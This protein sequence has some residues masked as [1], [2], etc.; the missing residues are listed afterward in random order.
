MLKKLIRNEW[1]QVPV[2]CAL[3]A[4]GGYLLSMGTVSGIVSPL[5]ASLAGICSPLYIFC[6]LLGSLLSYCVQDAPEGM[7]FLL[8][9][10]IAI[11]C[12]RIFFYDNFKPW[13]SGILTAVTCIGAGIML[14]VLFQGGEGKLPLYILESFMTGT[15]SFFLSDAVQNLREHRRIAL[16]GGKSFTFSICYLLIITALCGIDLEF[17]NLG[18]IIGMTVTLTASRQFRQSA[19]TLCGA[20][21]ACGV[22]LCSVPLGMPLLFLPVTAMLAGFLYQIPNAFYIPVFFLMQLFSSAVLDSSIGIIRILSELIISCTLYAVFCRTEFR[23]WI[24]FPESAPS[25]QKQVIQQEI[26]LSKALQELRE[27]TSAV[28]RHLTVITPP[29]PAEQVRETLCQNCPHYVQ[30]WKQNQHQTAQA[31]QQ[32]LHTPAV[33]PEALEHCPERKQLSAMMQVGSQ[34]RTVRQM[35]NVSLMQNREM[36]LEY[37]HLLEHVTA[38][39]AR[40]RA[41][42]FCDAETAMLKNILTRCAVTDDTGCFVCKLRSGRY[43]AEIYS[44]QESFPLATIQELL[45]RQLDTELKAIS[46]AH[47]H[48]TRYCLYEVP[49]YCM[50][51]ALRSQNA[52]AYERC[53]DHA[54]AFTDAFGNQ[55]LVISDGMGS[56]S[57]ASL[58]SRIAVR[59]F[60]NMVCCDMP[61]DSAI[62]LM[63]ALL[64]TET[65]TENFATLDIVF[66]NADTGEL[67]FCKSG[68]AS[69]LF[70]RD[71]E[72]HQ[73]L[74]QSFP[75]GIVPDAPPSRTK[76]SAQDGD[77]VILLSDGISEAEYP[78]IRQLL[79]QNSSPEQLLNA[80]FEKA[81]VFHGGTVRDDMTVITA[82]VKNQHPV[83]QRKSAPRKRQHSSPEAVIR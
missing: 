35:Q 76:L 30:C 1:F 52:P 27:E 21:T 17:C 64:M 54:D 25:G 62:R 6:I 70:C 51:Y 75:L 8:T 49:A 77:A 57:P 43:T 23:K 11:L 50:E 63:N 10:L 38:D 47:K 29:E 2:C 55:Y 28:M 4:S 24:S 41:L 71:G 60:R 5:A 80:V 36:M 13:V 33:L 32:M 69:A 34:R 15:A 66:L 14:D 65:N 82:C 48:Q 72:M 59:T 81:P 58:A 26:F 46:V 83:S 16:G 20:L 7:Q 31:F 18:R 3:S 22:V 37:L 73:I 9:S 42:Q 40:R 12:I 56:G 74:A 44:G 79:L 39:S 78:Y 53:G 19:G 68:S 61:V 45:S 67:S